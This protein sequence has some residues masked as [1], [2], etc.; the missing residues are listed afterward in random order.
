MTRRRLAGQGGHADNAARPPSSPETRARTMA[1][2]GAVLLTLAVPHASAQ[3]A[4]HLLVTV[5]DDAGVPVSGLTRNDFMVRRGDAEIE[6]VSVDPAPSTVQVVAIFEGLAV[7]QRHLTAGLSTFIGSLDEDSVVDMQSVDDELD[8]AIVQ[9]ID[10]LVA[11]DAPRP[12]ILMLG[13][14]SEIA[15]SDFQSSQVR[16][17][18]R[19]RDLT[20]DIDHLVAQL[21]EHGIL[22]YGLSAAQIPLT[23]FARL[24]QSTGGAFRILNEPAELGETVEAIGRELG[25][26]Y[27]LVVS[28]P[29]SA[30][31][32]EVTVTLRGGSTVRVGRL[33]A[34]ER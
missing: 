6:L 9:A 4:D 15:P 34:A 21:V 20:G 30:E 31:L 13:Q 16:G 8:A 27:L 33:R 25:A 10:D 1:L 12:V 32:P 17:R 26:Q 2:A 3:A 11:R 18:R 23:N 22:F 24:A 14:A 5:L 19:A 7:P 28:P 29:A